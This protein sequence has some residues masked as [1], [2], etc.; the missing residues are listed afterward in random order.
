ML[1]VT[2]VADAAIGICPAVM[3]DIFAEPAAP[4]APVGPG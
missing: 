4:V 2:V 3:P 1:E